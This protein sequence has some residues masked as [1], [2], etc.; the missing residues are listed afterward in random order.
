VTD[1]LYAA[2]YAPDTKMFFKAGETS[3]IYR[4]VDALAVGA[5]LVV[6]GFRTHEEQKI[7]AGANI[8]QREMRTDIDGHF[9]MLA[10]LV[11]ATAAGGHDITDYNTRLAD[12]A[13][14]AE[15]LLEA[16][17]ASREQQYMADAQKLLQPL[18]DERVQLRVGSGGYLPGFDLQSSGPPDHGP[19]DVVATL[20]VLQAARHYDRD[21]GDH[22][23][24][25]EETAAAALMTLVGSDRKLGGD[26]GAG[27]PAGVPESGFGARSGLVTAL[28]VVVLGDVARDLGQA[29]ASPA[30]SSSP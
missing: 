23:A 9:G 12:Q 7:Q 28:A 18:L 19:S 13:G 1:G 15:I 16:F 2:W 21:D 25:L 29:T 20:L 6:G 5:A 3:T 17:D 10:G 30:T 26:P 27:L 22:F 14:A 11:T 4:P 8:I 24:R